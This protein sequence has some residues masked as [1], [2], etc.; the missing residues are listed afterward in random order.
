MLFEKPGTWTETQG[1]PRW[2]KKAEQT[3]EGRK[4]EAEAQDTGRGRDK[5]NKDRGSCTRSLRRWPCQLSPVLALQLQP[6]KCPFSTHKAETRPNKHTWPWVHQT[7]RRAVMGSIYSPNVVHWLTD[8]PHLPCPHTVMHARQTQALISYSPHR[9]PPRCWAQVHFQQSSHINRPNFRRWTF[10]WADYSQSSLC[11]TH[12]QKS[13]KSSSPIPSLKEPQ[14]WTC[15]H[16]NSQFKP[17]D[18]KARI[19]HWQL[20]VHTPKKTRVKTSKKRLVGQRHITKTPGNVSILTA[21]NILN[22]KRQVNYTFRV[23]QEETLMMM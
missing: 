1:S 16:G 18:D 6:W 11:K 9:P 15:I 14:L 22:F 4:R 23:F 17:N 21:H 7:P 20:L 2:Q 12:S 19:S 10:P 3:T 5:C 8:S 13:F